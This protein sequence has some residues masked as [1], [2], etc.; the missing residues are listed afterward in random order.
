MNNMCLV[1][2]IVI[3]GSVIAQDIIYFSDHVL[4]DLAGVKKLR[5]NKNI[6]FNVP[7]RSGM[8]IVN[9]NIFK[10]FNCPIGF[11]L[12]GDCCIKG[13]YDNSDTFDC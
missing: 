7:R 5:R 1:V 4:D 12:V 3:L 11:E 10:D 13:D 6:K 2:V 9:K 8:I